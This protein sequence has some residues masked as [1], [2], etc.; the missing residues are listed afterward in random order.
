[1]PER[2]KLERRKRPTESKLKEESISLR[3]KQKCRQR[4]Y[5]NPKTTERKIHIKSR[6]KRC[7]FS[8]GSQWKFCYWFRRNK[9]NFVEMVEG[10]EEKYTKGQLAS[11]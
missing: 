4:K 1:L 6:T 8:V 5:Q 10:L 11:L 2:S 9:S 7:S 3:Q